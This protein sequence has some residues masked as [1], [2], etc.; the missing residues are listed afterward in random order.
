MKHT[1]I[2][3]LS[4][5]ALSAALAG[6]GSDGETTE[7]TGVDT[8]TGTGG[9]DGGGGTPA[10]NPGRLQ[11]SASSVTVAEGAGN[12]TLT[13]TRT[14][15]TDGAVSVTVATSDGS[16]VQPQD[17]T[18]VSTTVTFAAGDAAAKTVNLP[19]I[20]DT[21][22]E[23]GETLTVTLSAPTGNAALGS[24]SQVLITITDDDVAAPTAPKAVLSSAYKHLTIDWTAVPGATSYRLMKDDTGGTFTQIGTDLPASAHSTDV[25]VVVHKE[26]WLSAKYAV[27]ACNLAGCTQSPALSAAGLSVPMIGYLKAPD[28]ISYGNF[29]SAVAL[30]ADGNTLAVGAERT[31]DA[32]TPYSGSVLVYTRSGSDWVGPVTLKATNADDFDSFGDAVALSAD[33]NTLV[34]GAPYEASGNGTPLDNSVPGAG[35]AYIFIR[36]AGGT[37]S[38]AAYLKSAETPSTYENFGESVALS[39]DG[40]VAAV[41]IPYRTIPTGPIGSAGVVYLFASTGGIWTRTGPITAPTPSA[42]ANF[43]YSIALSNEGATLAVGAWQEDVGA[44]QS[45]GSAF[46]YARSGGNWSHSQTIVADVP[47]EYGR[48]GA[49]VSIAHDGSRLAVGAPYENLPPFNVGDPT[50]YSAGAAYLYDL[51]PGG[52]SPVARL[53]AANADQSDYFGESVALSG[54]GETLAVGSQSED[55]GG[56]GANPASDETQPSAGA[57]YV[58]TRPDATWSQRSYLKAPNPESNDLFGSSVT[59]SGDGNMLAVGSRYEESGAIGFNG[60]QLDDCQG[61]GTHCA[62]DSGAVYLY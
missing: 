23:T 22:A 8:S 26:N 60:N 27:A 38:Q 15:G 54:D 10:R 49:S 28:A 20:N 17:Y 1:T 43:G 58:F 13:V 55:G 41:G 50:L 30:S 29:G 62:E 32:V 42:S 4:V 19:I 6:C 33:G 37:W 44:L 53:S 35:A 24:A 21:T 40:T 52:A 25:D 3:F 61:A 31:A 45:A 48:F 12:T 56:A 16:A 47:V 34:V 18:A 59:V 11:F 51:S 46:V 5:L 39:P 36:S 14:D 2:G 9:S 57:V 7:S